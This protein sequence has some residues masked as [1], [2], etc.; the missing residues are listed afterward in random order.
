MANQ[1]LGVSGRAIQE[2]MLQNQWIKTNKNSTS[3]RIEGG[4]I[5]G[6]NSA[7]ARRTEINSA[8]RKS[9]RNLKRLIPSDVVLTTNWGPI[10]HGLLKS[11]Q[12]GRTQDEHMHIKYSQETLRSGTSSHN[13]CLD[14]YHDRNT[15]EKCEIAARTQQ[16]RRCERLCLGSGTRPRDVFTKFYLTPKW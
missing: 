3:L 12:Y 11:K 1:R 7:R 15:S 2:Q 9:V 14:S 5:W 10:F 8:K 4:L 16:N 6:K 13:Q